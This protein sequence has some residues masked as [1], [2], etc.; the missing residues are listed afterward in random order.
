MLTSTR[1]DSPLIALLAGEHSG[2]TLGAE[3]MQALQQQFPNAR[4]IGVGGPKMMAVGLTSLVPMEDLAVMG[5]AEVVGS[6]PRLLRHRRTILKALKLAQP[7]VFIGIDAPDFN[8]P[9]EHKLKAAGIPTVHYVSPSV[10]AWRQGRIHGIKAATNHV[11]CLLPFERAFYDQHHAPATFVGHP[12]ADSL[13]LLDYSMAVQE[14]RLIDA[15]EQLG[16]VA[17]APVV[18]LLPGSRSGE[19]ARLAPLYLR[20]ALLLHQAYPD[21]QFVAPMISAARREQF[22]QI[23]E[24]VAPDL[25]LLIVDGQAQHVMQAADVILV[26]SGTVTLEAM[27]L[28]TPMVV[29]YNF[30]WLSFQFIKRLFKAPFFSLPNLLA[31]HELVPELV[32]SDVTPE[33]LMQQVRQLLDTDH[34][35]LKRKFHSLHAL[36]K[37][38]AS[39]TSAAVIA[40]ILSNRSKK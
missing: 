6:L 19:I 7:D 2:D 16:L 15:R 31:Q 37:Q 34:T 1:S 11:L 27:L 20:A 25:P 8:L 21:I 26:T 39:A 3:L 12:L 35:E 10:W 29:A 33:N 14:Q 22:A 18:G 9:I 24:S 36:L 5:L 38:D 13:P 32:Q 30:N 4:F 17:T 40:T 28:G 23:V